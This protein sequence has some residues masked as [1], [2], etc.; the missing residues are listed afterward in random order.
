MAEKRFGAGNLVR[1]KSGGPQMTFV[2]YF[3]Q[4]G[5]E[6]CQCRWWDDKKKAFQ[7]ETF[8]EAELDIDG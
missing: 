8:T 6:K 7:T 4:Y 1:L 3:D 5:K 2:T